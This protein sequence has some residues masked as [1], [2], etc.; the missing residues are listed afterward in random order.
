MT[1]DEIIIETILFYLEDPARRAQET[2]SRRCRYLIPEDGRKC[3]VGRC[4]TGAALAE[5]GD[6]R[7]DFE[8][9]LYDNSVTADELL[10]PQYRGHPPEFWL[11]LQTVHDREEVWRDTPA[12]AIDRRREL[13]RHFGH[14]ASDIISKLAATNPKF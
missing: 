7:V 10:L 11:A 3:A 2:P 9:L 14:D 13:R 8:T 6:T 5:F 1:T 12:G 4:M